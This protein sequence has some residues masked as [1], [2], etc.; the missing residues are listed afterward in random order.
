MPEEERPRERFIRCGPEALSTTELLA[1]LF[2]SGTKSQPVLQLAQSLLSHFGSLEAIAEASHAELCQVKGIGQSKALQLKA[3]ITLGLRAC[4]M[5]TSLRCKIEN[6]T[7]AYH[8]LKESL[9]NEKREVCIVLLQDQKGYVLSQHTVAVGALDSASFQPREI[10]Y[11][12]IRHCAASFILAHNH[13][14]G[15]PTPSAEDIETTK[16][17]IAA[18]K[19]I[20][21]ALNDHIIIGKEGFISLRQQGLVS[22]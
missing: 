11:P 17:L 21:I 3:A 8:F 14:S 1:I 2:G 9:E 13:P 4:R 10:F 16:A 7:H 12:A 6:P 18:S 19:I 15:D 22:F 5:Q 20:A